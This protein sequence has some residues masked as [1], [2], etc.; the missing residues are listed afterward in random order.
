MA[1]GPIPRS[2][3]VDYGRDE[4]GLDGEALE[5]FI[6]TIREIDA[7]YLSMSSARADEALKPADAKKQKRQKPMPLGKKTLDGDQRDRLQNHSHPRL[8]G[9]RG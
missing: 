9:G 5:R 8:V 1:I 4:L 7:D 3:I 2:K 6:N